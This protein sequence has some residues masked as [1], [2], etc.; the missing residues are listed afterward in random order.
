M[1]LITSEN[2]WINVVSSV[3]YL[4]LQLKGKP[5]YVISSKKLSFGEKK[6]LVRSYFIASFNHCPLDWRI[7]GANVFKK[8]QD[9]QKRA[10]QSL[11]VTRNFRT[12]NYLPF[13]LMWT[14]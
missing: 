14:V 12:R 3:K 6:I 9:P 10:K 7:S 13:P 1:E 4:G 11:S 8:I 5:E 2:Q